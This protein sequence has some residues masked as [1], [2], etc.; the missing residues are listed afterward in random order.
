MAKEI[1]IDIDELIY[2]FQDHSGAENFLDTKTGEIIHISELMDEE[3]KEK[4]SMQIESELKRYLFIP[5]ED[6][7]ES[8][9]DMLD[10][11]VTLNN[12]DLKEKL[13]LTLKGKGVFRRFKDVL[14]NYPDERNMWF[15]FKEGRTKERVNE[16]LEENN[17]NISSNEG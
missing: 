11:A 12:E 4:I 6:S 9:N 8:Y 1:N 3:E 10:F 17:I 14:S 16:W 15:G 13:L 5:S 7:S 2:T